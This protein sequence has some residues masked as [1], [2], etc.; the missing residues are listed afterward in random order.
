LV[1]KSPARK[2]SVLDYSLLGLVVV[3]AG[4]IVIFI[5]A[6]SSSGKK[7][8]ENEGAKGAGVVLIGPIPIIFGNDSRLLI[9]AIVLAMV[10]VAL[11]LIAGF[12]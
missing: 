1:Y 9:I 7:A 5:A 6:L 3:L 11:A 12:W 4:I 10:L 8:G 2:I